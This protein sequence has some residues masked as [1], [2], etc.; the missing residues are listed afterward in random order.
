[1]RI[2]AIRASAPPAALAPLVEREIHALDADMPIADL[3]TDA[4]GR[5]R[6]A[7]AT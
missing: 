2:V 6:P 4:A 5:R 1:M 3:M 7:S